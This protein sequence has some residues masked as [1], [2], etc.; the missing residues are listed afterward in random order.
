MLQVRCH[1]VDSSKSQSK[2]L[3]GIS[4]MHGLL[5]QEVEDIANLFSTAHHTSFFVPMFY[6]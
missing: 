2:R 1:L 5:S 6:K 3:R 4:S